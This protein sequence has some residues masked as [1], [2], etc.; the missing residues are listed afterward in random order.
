V[1][2]EFPIKISQIPLSS[3]PPFQ[4]FSS[5]FDALV[6]LSNLELKFILLRDI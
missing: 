6:S 4:Y 2:E 1:K 3:S 5:L